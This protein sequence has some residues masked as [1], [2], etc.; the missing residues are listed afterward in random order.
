MGL[1]SIF[2]S[3]RT[4]TNSAASK[5][6]LYS[7]GTYQGALPALQSFRCNIFGDNVQGASYKHGTRS[8]ISSALSFKCR[9]SRLFL[10]RHGQASFL[11]RNYDKLS[12][13]GEEQSRILGKYWA[14]LNLSFDRVYSGPRV[15]QRETARIVGEQYKAAGLPWPGPGGAARSS[16]SSRLNSSWNAA[17][18][19]WW[20]RDSDI[21]RMHQAFQNRST[22]PEQFKTFQQIFEVIIGRWA[23]GKTPAGR[24]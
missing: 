23:D 4:N 2:L 14:G 8:M 22:R 24:D 16:M 18:R 13:K 3:L 9:M 10:V 5:F 6:Q 17:C 7:K 12:A 15:R 21:R 1:S 19:S 11:E 20:K